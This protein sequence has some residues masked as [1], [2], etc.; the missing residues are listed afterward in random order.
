MNGNFSDTWFEA[1]GGLLIERG[2]F[3]S[4]HAT[5]AFA[6]AQVFAERYHRHKIVPFV[7][8]GLAGVVAFSRVSTES[9]FPSDIVA[10]A[11]FGV[12]VSHFVVLKRH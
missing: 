6:V 8:Y 5:G 7:A 1:D 4:G 12:S 2:S 3:V 10:G 11:G 9:H